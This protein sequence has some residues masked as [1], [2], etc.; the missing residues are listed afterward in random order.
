MG[1]D[2]ALVRVWAR[3][4]DVVLGELREKLL[5]AEGEGARAR[6]QATTKETELEQA[7]KD[8]AAQ[9]THAEAERAAK[10]VAREDRTRLRGSLRKMEEHMGKIRQEVGDGRIRQILA[11]GKEDG[12]E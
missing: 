10:L 5:E 3:S 2:K 7:L 1:P 12:I 4:T 8:L 9:T 6:H 11:I